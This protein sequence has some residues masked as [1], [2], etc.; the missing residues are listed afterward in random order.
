MRIGRGGVKNIARREEDPDVGAQ[1]MVPLAWAGTPS[2][3]HGPRLRAPGRARDFLKSLQFL[4]GPGVR[5]LT[6]AGK[7]LENLHFNNG[8]G[9]RALKDQWFYRTYI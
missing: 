3:G 9:A 5:A 1:L 2:V 7:H 6:D 4:I 8:F